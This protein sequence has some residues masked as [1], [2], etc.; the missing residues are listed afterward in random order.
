M[1][2][3]ILEIIQGTPVVQDT[4]N[5]LVQ[6][7]Q[8]APVQASLSLWDLILKVSCSVFHC[9]IW[10]QMMLK[11]FFILLLQRNLA[12]LLGLNRYDQ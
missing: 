4:A 10:I 8:Q 12:T 7:T 3:I 11:T 2:G 9:T 5:H 1:L 6:A